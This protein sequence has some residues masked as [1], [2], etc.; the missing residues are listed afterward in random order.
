MHRLRTTAA[1]IL[2]ALFFTGGAQGFG[3]SDSVAAEYH[4][5]GTENLAGDTNFALARALL[6]QS[7][8]SA[9]RNLLFNQLAINIAGRLRVESRAAA[10]IRPLLDDLF[11]GESL[12]AFGGSGPQMD[13]VIAVRLTP[14][15][16]AVWRQSFATLFRGPGETLSESGFAGHSWHRAGVPDVSLLEA[17]GW[18][19]VAGGGGLASKRQTYLQTLQQEGRPAPPLLNNWLELDADWARLARW[20]PISD[21]PLKPARTVLHVTARGGRFRINGEILYPEDIA[22]HSSPW[23]PPKNLVSEP[24]VSFTTGQDVEPFLRSNASLAGMAADPFS[25]EF[26]CWAVGDMPLQTYAAWPV[27]NASQKLPEEESR[28][29]ATFNPKFA[30]LDHSKLIWNSRLSNIHWSKTSIMLPTLMASHEDGVDYFL[31]GLF[32]LS[33]HA[34]P[35]PSDLWRQ[36]DGRTDL[37]YYDWERTGP[38]LQQWRILSELLPIL[39][40]KTGNSVQRTPAYMIV[41]NW[42]AGLAPRLGTTVTQITQKSPRELALQRS[43]PFLFTSV[44]LMWLS[45]WLTDTPSGPVNLS[46]L[47]RAKMSGPGLAPH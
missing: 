11:T 47:P 18:T 7:S 16:A 9:F 35:V 4:F 24:L 19:V 2:T 32:P 41:D 36:F 30:R 17:R 34:R 10:Q 26:F 42:L 28:L 20:I 22:W 3:V 15:R 1:A 45:H 46:L 43:S 31:A 25:G 44:E 5:A 39:P 14:A 37:V 6:N 27:P 13:F 12:G 29:L 23:Q 8:S 21:L 40:V 33:P 38:R